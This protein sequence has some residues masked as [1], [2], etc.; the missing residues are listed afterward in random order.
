M[1]QDQQEAQE[2]E[3][4]S[5]M[6]AGRTPLL[7]AIRETYPPYLLA[8][9]S[10]NRKHEEVREQLGLLNATL[11][12]SITKL[13]QSSRNNEDSGEGMIASYEAMSQQ[14]EAVAALIKKELPGLR[15]LF[16]PVAKAYATYQ[17]AI[18][19]YNTY[20][21][22]WNGR[23]PESDLSGRALELVKQDIEKSL[24]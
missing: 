5:Q 11:S 13:R 12:T 10:Y 7:E 15:K 6:R 19:A 4:P 14:A 3:L 21:E 18:D 16:D 20:M 2:K 17:K 1:P 22:G 23:L 24:R 8:R 9:K